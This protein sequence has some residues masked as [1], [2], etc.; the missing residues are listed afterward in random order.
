MWHDFVW[1][2]FLSTG[3]SRS[4]REASR[5]R[6]KKKF[7]N[8]EGDFSFHD[9]SNNVFRDYYGGRQRF[10]GKNSKRM[11]LHFKE[12]RSSKYYVVVPPLVICCLNDSP[13]LSYL[14]I[15]NLKLPFGLSALSIQTAG[16]IL[17]NDPFGRKRGSLRLYVA[18]FHLDPMPIGSSIEGKQKELF[19]AI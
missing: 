11:L 18:G 10:R 3:G 4:K 14:I 19:A 17:T 7:S 16:S 8:L 1:N 6:N 12:H 2:F 9:N 15:Y 13:I 5:R